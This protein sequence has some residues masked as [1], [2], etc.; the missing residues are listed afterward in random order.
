M[1]FIDIVIHGTDGKSGLMEWEG[2]AVPYLYLDSHRTPAGVPAPLATCG[3][4]C[5]VQL[6]EALTLPWQIDGIAASQQQIQ[7][8]FQTVM[9]APFGYIASYYSRFTTCRL[10]AEAMTDLCELRLAVFVR[11]LEGIFPQFNT[12]P[13]TC[14][15]GATDLI[16]GTGIAGFQQY[17]HFIAACQAEDWKTAAAQSGSDVNVKA[18]ALRNQARMTLFL[19]AAGYP[20]NFNTAP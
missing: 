6:A 15:A 8:D 7:T 5:A 3:I 19:T 11:A 20:A 9:K 1:S 4:G 18:Y 12:W 17:R 10:T 14:K 2:G 16:Y 13:D